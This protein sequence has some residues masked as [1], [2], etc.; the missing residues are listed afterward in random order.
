MGKFTNI[1]PALKCRRTNGKFALLLII[2]ILFF[3]SCHNQQ[4]A[5]EEVVTSN[6]CENLIGQW[7]GGRKNSW[8]NYKTVI[9]KMENNNYIV[10]IQ[11]TGVDGDYTAICQDGKLKV[12]GIPMTSEVFLSIDAFYLLG[13]KFHKVN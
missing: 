7:E 4:G 13:I 10:T 6:S 5:T 11:G 3:S 2:S 12:S 9:I 1:V 8:G